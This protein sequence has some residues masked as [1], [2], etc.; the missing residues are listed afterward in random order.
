MD[1][2]LRALRQCLDLSPGSES[3]VCADDVGLASSEA[4]ALERVRGVFYAAEVLAGL[5]LNI[6]KCCIVP[7]EAEFS[8]FLQKQIEALLE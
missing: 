8:P 2:L 5:Q 6:P 1:P 3:G 7:L 4:K